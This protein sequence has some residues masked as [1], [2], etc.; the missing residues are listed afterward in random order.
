MLDNGNLSRED[1]VYIDHPEAYRLEQ[2]D[3]ASKQSKPSVAKRF[4]R[5][6]ASIA[7]MAL[8]FLVLLCAFLPPIFSSQGARIADNIYALKLPKVDAF[9]GS[10]FLDGSYQTPINEKRYYALLGI[11]ASS[12]DK[13]GAS[14]DQSRYQESNVNPLVHVEERYEE[15]GTYY[16]Q[17]RIDSYYEVGYIYEYL[18]E[19]TFLS[20]KT[21]ESL[22][23]LKVLYP[24]I[25]EKAQ[26]YEGENEPNLFY[27]SRGLYPCDS[28][29]KYIAFDGDIEIS[30]PKNTVLRIFPNYLLDEE[31]KPIYYQRSGDTYKVRL[32]YYNYFQY[33]YWASKGGS[34]YYCSPSKLLGSDAQGYDILLR[35]SS[36]I[37]LS[38]LFSITIFIINYIIGTLY[39]MVEGYYGG[40]VDLVLFYLAE[41][42][43]ALPFIVL[44]SLFARHFI[45]KGFM[46][47][48]VGLMLAFLLT[49]WI[50]I[51][52]Q[53]RR[54]VYRFK[55]REFVDASRIAGGS[56]FYLMRKHIYP[57]A[58]SSL[59]TSL[60]L[61]I[62]GVIF[63]ETA[64][65]FLGIIDFNGSGFTSL[66]TM[67]GNGQNYIADY[68]HV[69]LLPALIISILMIAFN[70]LGNG[71]RDAFSNASQGGKRR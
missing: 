71:L 45:A 14:F 4:F 27:Y 41:I 18:D 34:A 55:S 9:E 52:S 40:K 51:A 35:T 47:T 21:Y 29:G 5:S 46:T 66:G 7:G 65:S 69:I 31:D 11:G 25:N 70:F 43:R 53:T 58:V 67:I 68:P 24:L 37:Q 22:S 56:D 26:C 54:Q 1:F 57:H 50:S 59:I 61:Y 3:I 44:A 19:D 23:G 39:G 20:I 32:L 42:L 63:N 16:Y 33:K 28:E 2:G 13:D 36:G 12:L 48:F 64:L 8:L 6:P 38:L 49:G 30:N 60:V 15:E 10:G 62:P 17:A